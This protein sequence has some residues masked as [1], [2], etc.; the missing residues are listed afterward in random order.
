MDASESYL[1]KKQVEAA[2]WTAMGES[3]ESAGKKV[4]VTGATV[5]KW[6]QNPLYRQLVET[7]CE[8][9]ER[10]SVKKTESIVARPDR[11]IADKQYRID[12]K[13]DLHDALLTVMKE[14]GEAYAAMY[15]DVAGGKTG[16]IFPKKTKFGIEHCV[17]NPTIAQV[18]SIHSEVAAELG[19]RKDREFGKQIPKLV[20]N[21]TEDDV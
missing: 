19:Q 10:G 6:R 13:N 1:T 5:A 21:I 16:L 18:L 2:R 3:N 4:G 9:I 17:D 15:P 12:V 7:H 20:E 8:A 14:R 11:H